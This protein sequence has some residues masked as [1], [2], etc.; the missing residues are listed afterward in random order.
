MKRLKNTLLI[1]CSI[2]I[3]LFSHVKPGYSQID[4]LFPAGSVCAGDIKEYTLW[5]DMVGVQILSVVNGKFVVAD[6]LYYNT[7]STMIKLNCNY[8]EKVTIKW[9]TSEP[10][11]KAIWHVPNQS[12]N[13]QGFPIGIVTIPH[14]NEDETETVVLNGP[15]NFTVS[16]RQ[17]KKD[18]T[19]FHDYRSSNITKLNVTTSEP[20]YSEGIVDRK[21][22]YQITGDQDGWVKFQTGSDL[23]SSLYSEYCIVDI[24]RK[25]NPP[26]F[27]QSY[28]TICNSYATYSVSGDD[29]NETYTWTVTN[30]LKIYKNNQYL[31]TYTG[32]EESVPIYKPTVSNG[33]GYIK[34]KAFANGYTDS[35]ET[36]KQIWFGDIL[37]MSLQLTDLQMGF[38]KYEFCNGDANG[39]KA[40]HVDGEAFIDEW[41]WLVTGGYITIENPYGDKSK[42]T[43]YP[44]SS[45][46][47]SIKINAHNAC[48]WSGWA[49]IGATVIVCGGYY[50]MISPNPADSYIELTFFEE[51]EIA[52][53]KNK[54]KIKKSKEN[55]DGEIEEYLVQILDKNGT[56]RKSVKSKTMKVNIPT[57]DLEPGTYFLHL[58]LGRETYKQQLIIK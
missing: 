49:D 44:Q 47:F 25:L 20:P 33:N 45:S 35:E 21:F 22:T 31:T 1:S 13:E 3:V 36:S 12:N 26:S 16:I 38:P 11:G 52:S 46:S 40:V 42:A 7:D 14:V 18:D 10:L 56:I 9:G 32:T 34:V 41:D 43:I 28:N 55:K 24:N 6:S 23:C 39:V 48:G 53:S 17:Y 58:R 27:T 8:H 15:N 29:A 4:F 50:M 54:V 37:P 2:F 51:D 57:K 30:G 19:S 5:G